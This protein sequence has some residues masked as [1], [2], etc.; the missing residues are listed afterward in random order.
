MKVTVTREDGQFYCNVDGNKMY[1]FKHDERLYSFIDKEIPQNMI[2]LNTFSISGEL[3]WYGNEK[4][5]TLFTLK[6]EEL[7]HEILDFDNSHDAGY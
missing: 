2:E 3:D 1:P 5:E 6:S 4:R 7:S